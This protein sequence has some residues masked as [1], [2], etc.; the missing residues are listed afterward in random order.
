MSIV[1][2]MF[3]KKTLDPTSQRMML[4][5]IHEHFSWT[6][7]SG[8]LEEVG[9]L[10]CIAASHYISERLHTTVLETTELIL[11]GIEMIE[12]QAWR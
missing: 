9:H 1:S 7:G 11:R 10:V 4:P 2:T 5:T 12:S 8:G 6:L 3:W